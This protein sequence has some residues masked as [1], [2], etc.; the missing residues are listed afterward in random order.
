MGYL[1]RIQQGDGQPQQRAAI[2][3]GN[4]ECS[5][6][7]ERDALFPVPATILLRLSRSAETKSGFFG[8]IRE[9]PGT[10]S[11]FISI[12]LRKIP[13]RHRN[14]MGRRGQLHR[15][16]RRRSHQCQDRQCWQNLRRDKDVVHGGYGSSY[17]P[18]STQHKWSW[19]SST[20]S[21]HAN[22]NTS[23]IVLLDEPHN[24]LSVFRPSSESGGNIVYKATGM[25][26][27]S[28]TARDREPYSSTIPSTRISTM[29]LRPSKT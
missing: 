1:R 3:S 20:E 26:N 17:C 10:I 11:P 4:A 21:L 27:P 12:G 5:H 6:S 19:S 18:L 15:V 7:V 29:R 22:T 2:T 24:R 8:A 23:G 9:P 25:S 14:R 13:G 28:F 16:M